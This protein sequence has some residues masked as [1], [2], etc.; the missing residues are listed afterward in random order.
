MK[1]NRDGLSLHV[2]TTRFLGTRSKGQQLLDLVSSIDG[3][4]WRPD[5]WGHFE[6]IRLPFDAVDYPKMLS[7]WT[8]QRPPGSGR[9]SNSLGFTRSKPKILI[10]ATGRRLRNVPSLNDIWF[11]L[12]ARPFASSDGVE[13]LI[14]MMLAVVKWTDGVYASMSHW[15]Q[16]HRRIVQMTPLERLQ[17]LDWLTFFGAPYIEMF[18]RSRL[19]ATPCHE[20][21]EVE[22]GILLVAAPR[23]DG[24]EMTASDELLVTLENYLG[25]NAFAGRGYPE[26]PCRVPQFDLSE[27]IVSSA[28]VTNGRPH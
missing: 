24:P 7:A 11:D 27:L 4:R 16:A 21:R 17:R 8:E 20:V 25:S 12:D 26:K 28:T 23:P 18:G 1:S 13:R 15:K 22:G 3:G 5:K 9:V 6:P 2:W 19:L 14:D 10:W